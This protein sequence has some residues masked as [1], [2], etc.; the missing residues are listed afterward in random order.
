MF[1]NLRTVNLITRGLPRNLIICLPTLDCAYTIWRFLEERFPNYSLKNI[2]VIL[3]KSIA[4]SKINPND[5]MFGDCLFELHDLL[6]AKGD[7]RIISNII[8]EVIIIH[9]YEH[10]HDHT[11]NES[12]SLVDDQSQD[13][14]EHVYYEEDDDSDFDLDESMRHF[15]LMANLRGYMAGGKEWVLDSGCTDHMTGDKD[16]FCELAENDSPRKYVTFGDNSKDKVVGL[17]KV[18]ISHDS[19]IQNV[20]LVESLGYNLLS[21][22]RLAALVS[23]SNLLK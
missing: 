6:C 21:V 8:L 7:V 5:P 19:S 23:M 12:L 22:S 11:S 4:L 9:K 17:G 13:D 10:C 2:D 16:M 1:R 14:V 15:G 18:A 3:Q 20:M